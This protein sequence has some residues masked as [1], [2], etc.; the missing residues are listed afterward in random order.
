M[1][2]QWTELTACESTRLRGDTESAKWAAN[3]P[4]YISLLAPLGL[5]AYGQPISSS[6]EKNQ[7][8]LRQKNNQV[9]LGKIVKSPLDKKN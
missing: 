5:D 3:D 8:N 2:N 9:N 7:E 4:K 1:S 6:E